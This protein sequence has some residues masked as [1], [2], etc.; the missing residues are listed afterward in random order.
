MGCINIKAKKANGC[1]SIK[2]VTVL[3]PPKS[4]FA[5]SPGNSV[6]NTDSIKLKAS[7]GTY[8]LW[9][10]SNLNIANP[11]VKPATTTTYTVKIKDSVCNDSSV[12]TTTIRVLSLPT[13]KATKSNDVDCSNDFSQ[14]NATGSAK[15]IWQPSATLNNPN[16]SNPIARPVTKTL[17]TVTGYDENG[18]KNSDTITVNVDMN[19]I[20]KSGY[21]MPTAFTPNNDG[22]NDCFGLKF[23]GAVTKLSFSIYNRFGER[24]FYSTDSSKA[25]WDGTYK[26]VKQNVGA[27]VYIIQATTPCDVINRKGT[28]M[29][30][31]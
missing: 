11:I 6:C 22:L 25:C 12:L 30:L 19:A 7:G 17:F 29:I 28:V 15:Y 21:S 26:G 3:I 24:I 1:Y 9:Q 13:I 10:P 14:L 2:P 27:Y 16:I 18:C 8:Y 20:N 5:I 31:R 23:W 4:S